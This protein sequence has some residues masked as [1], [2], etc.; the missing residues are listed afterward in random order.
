MAQNMK[1]NSSLGKKKGRMESEED[2]RESKSIEDAEQFIEST[3]SVL[4][5]ELVIAGATIPTTKQP[6][7]T[8]ETTTAN[9]TQEPSTIAA[10]TTN[11]IDTITTTIDD[12]DFNMEPRITTVDTENVSNEGSENPQVTTDLPITTQR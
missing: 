3:E 12:N 10:D 6:E 7:T 5:E 11:T 1:I 8:I 2:T 4:S 9:I